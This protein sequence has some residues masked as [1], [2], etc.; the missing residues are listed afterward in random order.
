TGY[1]VERIYKAAYSDVNGTSTFGGPHQLSVPVV[2]YGEFMPDTQRIGHG[3]V[4]G[5]TGWEQVLENNKQN[6]A[7][8]FVQRSRFANAFPTS[9][10]PAQFVDKLFMN[11]GVTPSVSDRQVAIN[12]FGL[13]TTTADVAARARAL[14]D[15]ADN[16]I[17]N[18]QE[19]NRVFVLMQYFGYLR[20]TPT[21]TPAA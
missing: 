1:L 15:V 11:A 13:A 20:R 14:R 16:S 7:T 21:D 5:Q 8:R 4:I 10:T 19:F 18:S 17:L 3:V 12:E 2:R 6:F 9:V